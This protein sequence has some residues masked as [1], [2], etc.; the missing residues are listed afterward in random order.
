VGSVPLDS[1]TIG[2]HVLRIDRVGDRKKV[3][4]MKKITM[5][6]YLMGPIKIIAT[7]LNLSPFYLTK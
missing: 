5:I 6:H 2:T 3:G 1:P 4:E 7:V